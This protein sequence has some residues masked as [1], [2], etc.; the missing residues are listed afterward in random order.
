MFHWL[1]YIVT[2][3][4]IGILARFLLP[5]ADHMGLVMTILVGIGGSLLGGYASRA[6]SKPATNAG[7]HPAGFFVSLLGAIALLV[8]LRFLKH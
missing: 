7:F 5:G 4:V 8:V 1:Q 2:G 6:M 3:L